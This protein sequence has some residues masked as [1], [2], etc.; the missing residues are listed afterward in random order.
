MGNH[1]KQGSG[2]LTQRNHNPDEIHQEI[3]DPKVIRLRSAVRSS[4]DVMVEKA[5]RIIQG[6]TVKV[7]HAN[8]QLEWMMQGALRKN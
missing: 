6:V 5:G 7:T 1:Q 4:V 8:D 3:I 2:S